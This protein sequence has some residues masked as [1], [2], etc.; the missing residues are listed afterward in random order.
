MSRALLAQSMTMPVNGHSCSI[1]AVC[2]DSRKVEVGDL[3]LLLPRAGTRLLDADAADYL[4][5]A[6]VRGAGAV[7]SVDAALTGVET[8]GNNGLPHLQLATMDEAGHW[9]RRLFATVNS[10]PRCFGITGTDGKTSTTWMVRQA[11]ERLH[12]AAWSLG[13]LGL[14]RKGETPLALANTTPPLLCMQQTLA[15]AA[16]AQVVDLVCEVSSHGV[17][18]QRIAGMP[19]SAAL[20]SNIGSDHLEDHGGLDRY[21][22]LKANFVRRVVA[23]GGVAVAN[24][25]QPLVMD[26]LEEIAGQF[27]WYGRDG[28]RSDSRLDLRWQPQGVDAVWLEHGG[29]RALV[30]GVPSG[31][32]HQENCAAAAALLLHAGVEGLEQVAE[33]LSNMPP[34]PGRMEPIADGIYLDYAHTPEALRALLASARKLCAGR[35]LL[36]FGCG[37]DRDAGKRPLMGEIAARGADHCWLTRD[38]SRSEQASMIAAQVLAGIEARAKV[39]VELDRATAIAQAVAAKGAGDLLLIAGKGRESYMEEHG[40]RIPWSDADCVQLGLER[41]C[42]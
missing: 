17:A 13:T 37:G 33:S 32:I 35:L 38:N 2:D 28:H 12:G 4:Q 25:D 21:V 42:V 6:L 40:V 30:E 41:A 15:E 16:Q 9:L 34:P 20:W 31:D 14:I 39:S 19:F 3:F 1:A 22:A 29:A 27:F 8:G 18:Q 7:L 10:Y 26:A 23:Q 24:G 11:L 36:V 5:Q